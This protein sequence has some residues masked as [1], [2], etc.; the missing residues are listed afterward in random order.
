[1]APA[2]VGWGV[3]L[4]MAGSL[5]C[6]LLP[7]TFQ[8]PWPVFTLLSFSPLKLENTASSITDTLGF[9]RTGSEF[10]FFLSLTSEKDR[11]GKSE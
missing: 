5:L 4:M 11:A 10:T 9:K 8:L 7:G 3:L 2:G 1:M 6:L